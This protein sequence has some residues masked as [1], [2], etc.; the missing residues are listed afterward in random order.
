MSKYANFSVISV[1]FKLVVALSHL[2]FCQ[3]PKETRYFMTFF[4]VHINS[5]GL[6]QRRNNCS[7]RQPPRSV[8]QG[9]F[10]L[11]MKASPKSI[12]LSISALAIRISFCWLKS[13][14][15]R[16]WIYWIIIYPTGWPNKWDC[17]LILHCRRIGN[18]LQILA[19]PIWIP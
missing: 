2:Y 3:P 13:L 7:I 1:A 10:T 9:G 16:H 6:H 17:S 5:N 14:A 12:T 4:S 11:C 8:I 15:N 19:G 18:F